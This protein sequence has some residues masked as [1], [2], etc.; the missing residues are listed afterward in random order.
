[1]SRVSQSWTFINHLINYEFN[2]HSSSIQAL[3]CSLRSRLMSRIEMNSQFA[4]FLNTKIMCLKIDNYIVQ[5]SLN[6][7][8]SSQKSKTTIFSTTTRRR[9]VSVLQMISNQDVNNALTILRY[10]SFEKKSR[11]RS[12]QQNANN[13]MT[14][15]CYVFVFNMNT[16]QLVISS[17]FSIRQ[18]CLTFLII[19]Q[20]I[21]F[22]DSL[23]MLKLSTSE[24][25][26]E[27]KI[28]NENFIERFMKKFISWYS[29]HDLKTT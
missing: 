14:T 23:I 15:N 10:K 20:S 5:K 19:F 26:N 21:E 6:K 18:A 27:Q 28:S 29:H 24:L 4:S 12:K 9:S 1:M 22:L 25:R 11:E 16:S 13:T 3:T 17:S 2:H 8:S 7:Q